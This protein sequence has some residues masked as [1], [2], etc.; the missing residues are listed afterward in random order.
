MSE[1]LSHMGQH[2]RGPCQDPDRLLA[3]AVAAGQEPAT[4]MLRHIVSC[5][6]CLGQLRALDA[7]RAPLH[8]HEASPQARAEAE[9]FLERF[10][11]TTSLGPTYRG[12]RQEGRIASALIGV[13]SVFVAAVAGFAASLVVSARAVELSPFGAL[14]GALLG[15]AAM[16]VERRRGVTGA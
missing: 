6:E 8:Q 14:I 1:R 2:A 5:P 9:R 16:A 15:V 4:G 13:G 10:D 7:L 12:R 11:L 3:L